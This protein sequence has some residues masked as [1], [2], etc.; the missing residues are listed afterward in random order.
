MLSFSKFRIR[1]LLTESIDYSAVKAFDKEEYQ[2][3]RLAG[4]LSEE[5]L[6]ERIEDIHLLG[7]RSNTHVTS[8]VLEKAPHLHAVGAF[9]IGTNAIDLPAAQDNGTVVF[10]APFSNTRSVVELAIAEIIALNRGLFEKNTQMHQGVWNKS[11]IGSHE[12]R[13]K[14]LGI[15]GYGNIGSQLSVLAESLGMHC[16]YYDIADKLHLGNAIR[17]DI[18]EDLLMDSDIVTIHVDGR[19]ANNNFFGKK[20]F[21]AM[22]EGSIFLNLSRGG[23]VDLQALQDALDSQHIR[24]A[25]LD[26][27]PT[28]PKNQDQ[29]F[30]H[31]LTAYQ[32][33]ALT[34]HIAG[35]TLEAQC[36]IGGFVATK[37]I[38]FINSG[39]TALSVNMPQ[40]ELPRQSG[41]HRLILIHRNQPGALADINA[42]F[43]QHGANVTGQY[44]GTKDR[45]GF[46]VTD[47]DKEYG[48][49]LQSQL[50]AL[51]DTIRMRILY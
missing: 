24:T 25:A 32:Q 36:N 8:R 50:K 16:G 44:L 28:E 45:V 30:I 20:E 38:D 23:L 41:S 22:K 46:V 49:Q 21:T 7:V 13:G 31:R 15:V 5:E 10:N 18:L 33:V 27:F 47:I 51:P 14:R 1:V 11:T 40:L 48:E 2:V 39:S 29:P 42:V 19:A 9:C 43:A 37:M 35:S 34:P 4:A 26:V 12:V 3:T 17:Y 6:L